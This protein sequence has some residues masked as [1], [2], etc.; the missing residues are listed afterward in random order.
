MRAC[1]EHCRNVRGWFSYQDNAVYI[2]LDSDVLGNMY[3]RSILLHELVHYVQHHIDSPRL[4]NDCATWKAREKQAYKVQY[5]WLYRNR[6]PMRAQTFN[7]L[8]AGFS[9]IGCDSAGGVSSSNA[10]VE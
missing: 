10:P 5:D 9:G 4:H 3:D 7:T 2:T 6:V 8:L 1:S